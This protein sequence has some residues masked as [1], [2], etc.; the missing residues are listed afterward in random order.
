MPSPF[1][2]IDPYIDE[3][4]W[5]DFHLSLISVIREMLVPAIRPRY[6]VNVEQHVFVQYEEHDDPRRR[7]PD[8]HILDTEPARSGG[9]ERRGGAATAILAKPVPIELPEP[10]VVKQRYLTIR[11]LDSRR[12]VTVIEILSPTNKDAS[13][14]RAYLDKR[15]EILYGETGVHLVELDLLRGGLRL[16][17]EK[18]LPP[19]DFYV[20]VCRAHHWR[21]ADA[22][23]WTLR[24]PMPVIPIPLA[25]GDLDV[26]LDLQSAFTSVYDRAGYDYSLDYSAPIEPP[27]SKVDAEW[28]AE[29]LRSKERT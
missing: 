11:K 5:P 12:L 25:N 27:L 19:G 8:L 18:P 29:I 9:E 15:S 22:Y 4:T 16:P 2:G 13:N 14:R 23:P 21:Q 10:E 26:P 7:R 3:E 1:P 24:D 17:S 20:I 28:A 6:V